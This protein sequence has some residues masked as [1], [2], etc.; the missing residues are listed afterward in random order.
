[1]RYEMMSNRDVATNPGFQLITRE[2]VLNIE[3][4]STEPGE[5]RCGNLAR[6]VREQDGGGAAAE[7]LV[8][9]SEI[10]TGTS[11]R[12]TYTHTHVAARASV[13]F[14]LWNWT[15]NGPP[16]RKSHGPPEEAHGI[17]FRD[18]HSGS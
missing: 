11:L 4:L 13:K 8:P 15:P 10:L 16:N 14:M 6:T 2:G 7:K 5:C 3:G 18:E 12:R 1:M 17:F 9:D